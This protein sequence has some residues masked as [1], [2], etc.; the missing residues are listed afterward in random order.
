MLKAMQQQ[1]EHMNLMF[2]EIR[3]KLE[4]QDTAIA[5]LQRGQQPIAPNVR[6]NQ[7]SAVMGEEDGD[8]IDDFDDQATVDMRG[9]DNRR[10]RR[11]DRDLGSI[12]LQIPSFQDKNDPEAYLEWEKK[13]EL[14]FDCHN[15]SKEKKVK[16]AAVEFTDY[17]IIWWDQLVLS[18]R[19][20][21]ERPINTWEEM[22]AIMRRRFVPSHYY[23][24]LHQRL[25]SLIHGSRSV[26]D[27]HKEMEII[28]IRANIE[29]E[30]EATMARFL[31]GLNQ[32]IANVVDFQHYVE[33]EDMVH[34]AMK[35]ERQLKKKDDDPMPPLED[36]NDGVEYLV[37]GKLMVARRA[38]NMQVKEDAEDFDDVF[39]NEVPN[40]LPPIRG[41]EHQIDFVPGATIPNRPAYRSNPEET[42]ELQRQVEELLAKGYVR[43]SMS[44][45]AVPVLLV[46]KKD[47]TWRMSVDCCAINKITVKYR[48]PIPRLDDML[49][50]L[51]GSCV[52]SKIDL[53]SGYYQIRIREGDEWKTAFKTKYGLYEWLV[54][55]FGL[56]NARST[57]M[58]LMNHVLRAFIGIEVDEEKVK[59]FK[60]WPTPKSVSEVRSFHGLASFYRRFVKDFSTLPVPLT[61]IVKKHVGFKWDSEQERAFNLIKEKLVSAPLLALPDFTKTFEIECDASG[62]GIRA[63]LMQEGRPIAYFSEKLSGAA[64]NYPTY[65][66]EMYALV[67]ALET[68][69]HY[70]L[71][72][73]FV[74][75]TDHESLKHLKGY[76]LIS[77]LN[78]KLLGF[79]YIKELYVND[80]NFANVFNACEKVTF[81]HG[82]GLMGHFGISKTLDV[83]KEHFFWPH[84]KRDVERICE[85]CITCK[86]AKSRVLPHGLYNPLAIP[87]EPWV[88]ISMDFVLGLPRSK[89]GNDYVFVV[90]D[91]FSKM[92][93]FIPC[94]KT[95]DATN[96]ANLFFKEIVRLHG[97]P[98]SI[99]S[100]RDAKFLSHFWK[101]L[102]DLLPLPIDERA[103]MDGKKKAEFVKQLHERTHQHIEKRTEQYT[104]Q[105]NKGHKQVVFQPGDWVWVH[106]RKERFPAQR[107]SKLL[108]TGDGPFQVV[109]RINNNAYKLDL[110]GEDSRT[111]TFQ[112]RG[113]DENHQGNTIKTSSEPV[114]E[115]VIISR[116][117]LVE[118]ACES[119]VGGGLLDVGDLIVGIVMSSCF[120]PREVCWMS[121]GGDWT[122]FNSKR[123][124][125]GVLEIRTM[126]N[127]DGGELFSFLV[128]EEIDMVILD[129]GVKLFSPP[130]ERRKPFKECPCERMSL[131]M[132][133]IKG[134]PLKLQNTL[135]I[136]GDSQRRWMLGDAFKMLDGSSLRGTPC[137]EHLTINPGRTF[138]KSGWPFY[139]WNVIKGKP[140]AIGRFRRRIFLMRCRIEVLEKA[141]DHWVGEE[142]IAHDR[143]LMRTS[144][145]TEW[146][147]DVA[148]AVAQAGLPFVCK[149]SELWKGCFLRSLQGSSVHLMWFEVWKDQEHDFRG[150]IPVDGVRLP[151]LRRLFVQLLGSGS[152]PLE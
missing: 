104:T 128:R 54:M 5:K 75:H 113:N 112:E 109:A 76:A 95:D 92:V 118:G 19:R 122:L 129:D 50:E 53:K 6:G 93:H 2:G 96:I 33:L 43:E 22:K 17:A 132:R 84:M 139:S 148:R 124:G 142:E 47:G 138:L 116:T 3:D 55:P 58:R 82:G 87:S 67:R 73:E 91:R 107:R 111:N 136:N 44:P 102:W 119:V 39:P 66:K 98:R 18:R 130:R 81:A 149:G 25:Q 90:D 150:G 135:T 62:I 20:N 101:T 99:V 51:H 68:W 125:N 88:D 34:M 49:D 12:K 48:H 121:V 120:G 110:P 86:H 83:L 97:V 70:F 61:E 117:V 60:E 115:S 41:I 152:G 151:F 89:R 77:T 100:D 105:A 56:S 9:R 1:F 103:S 144:C 106:M 140:R 32:D 29:E 42:K 11:I 38:L 40:G 72:K 134:I 127:E 94:H 85:K 114:G 16:L 145:K 10:A 7:G 36:A 143:S 21:H 147:L 31:H 28:M 133:T 57:F 26:E 78:A 137:S 35:V 126:D 131:V 80:P 8:G 15:Y 146:V 46:P 27:Y 65:D 30:R 71:P 59:A 37:D 45:C 74:I 123:F 13:V 108:P 141:V 79:E 64:L 52:F 14:V 23:R 69:Q 24:E 63:V 4:R